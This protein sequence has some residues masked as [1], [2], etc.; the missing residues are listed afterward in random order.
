MQEGE[1]GE[2]VLGQARGGV[3]LGEEWLLPFG[4]STL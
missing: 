2:G 3:V 1:G 4:Q